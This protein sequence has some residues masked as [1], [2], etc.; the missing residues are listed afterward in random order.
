MEHLNLNDEEYEE[1]LR[2]AVIEFTL[3]EAHKN[4][5]GEEEYTELPVEELR[6]KITVLA[7]KLPDEY[8][9]DLYNKT[10]GVCHNYIFKTKFNIDV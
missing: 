8:I 1:L 4:F 5:F 9:L 6:E 3:S 7:N 2:D 10:L